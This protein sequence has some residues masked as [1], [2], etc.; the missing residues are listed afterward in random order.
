[1]IRTRG[2]WL[3][4]GGSEGKGRS[5]EHHV[6]EERGGLVLGRFLQGKAKHN[7]QGKGALSRD[8]QRDKRSHRKGWKI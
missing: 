8:K 2:G 7:L 6:K 5:L 3:T 1:L 4:F